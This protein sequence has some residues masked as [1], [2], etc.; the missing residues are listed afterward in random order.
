MLFGG[1]DVVVVGVVLDAVIVGMGLL[2]GLIIC[3]F[4]SFHLILFCVFSCLTIRFV[5]ILFS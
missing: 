1:N 3:L 5:S 2:F 4:V